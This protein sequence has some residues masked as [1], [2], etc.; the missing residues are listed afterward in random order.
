MVMTV[1]SHYCTSLLTTSNLNQDFQMY[2]HPSL[3]FSPVLV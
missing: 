1:D 3:F 2:F